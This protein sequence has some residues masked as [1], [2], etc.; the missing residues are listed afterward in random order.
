MARHTDI[1]SLLYLNHEYA[2]DQ[3]KAPP[4][5][6][7]P[8]ILTAFQTDDPLNHLVTLRNSSALTVI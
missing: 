7:N 8:S 2:Q 6:L 5:L 4:T 3:L 1:L